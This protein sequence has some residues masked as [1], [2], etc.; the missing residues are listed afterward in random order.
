MATAKTSGSLAQRLIKAASD[1]AAKSGVGNRVGLLNKSE[2]FDKDAIFKSRIPLVNLMFSGELTGGITAGSTMVVGDSRTFKSN[3]CLSIVSDFM[4]TYK[5]GVCIFVDSEFGS[6]PAYFNNAGIDT[7]RVIHIPVENIEQ[8]AF[9]LTSALNEASDDDKIIVFIDSISQAASKKEAT[10]MTDGN[11]TQDMTRARSLNSFWRVVTP[12]INLRKIPLLAI[13][14]FYDDMANKYAERHIKGGKQGFLSAD[15]I[16]FVTRR[17]EKDDKGDLAGY[18]FNYSVMKSRS[19]KEK[20][21]FGIH[22]TFEGGIDKQSGLFDLMREGDF[23][24]MPTNA[25]Y[26][27]NAST[28]LPPLPSNV[29][30][31]DIEKDEVMDAIAKTNAFREFVWNKYSLDAGGGVVNEPAAA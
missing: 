22:V 12:I 13:N 17:Q 27:I 20:S 8:M 30:K 4:D 24:T 18:T 21:V 29:R 9:S 2:Y 7:D 28:G 3:F 1:A 19:V 5:D 25:W 31:A 23:I 10:D 26:N 16:F 15:Q 6:R 14:S 11:S